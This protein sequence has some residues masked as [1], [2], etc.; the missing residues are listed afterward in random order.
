MWRYICALF[1]G[2]PAPDPGPAVV[3]ETRVADN[4]AN[5]TQQCPFY[6]ISAFILVSVTG[7]FQLQAP[8]TKMWAQA[9]FAALIVTLAFVA[10]VGISVIGVFELMP[11]L[12]SGSSSPNPTSSC[13]VMTAYALVVLQL[14][15][16]S[17]LRIFTGYNKIKPAA[18]KG[19]QYIHR[20]FARRYA[21]YPVAMLFFYYCY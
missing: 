8:S 5:A 4:T 7:C 19:N 1:I 18:T 2:V 11:M 13:C 14:I 3:A 17:G 10:Y 6:I 20:A 9:R 12:L 16:F 15:L 21:A